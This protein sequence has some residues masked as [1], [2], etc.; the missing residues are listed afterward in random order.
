MTAQEYLDTANP[1]KFKDFF[2]HA[3]GDMSYRETSKAFGIS[4]TVIMHAR[5][6]EP[7]WP[8]LATVK[9]IAEGLGIDPLTLWLKVCE[10]L[11]YSCE[12]YKLMRKMSPQARWE[13]KGRRRSY[14]SDY[15][16]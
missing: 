12:N 1:F 3:M 13:N 16:Y 11:F 2:I 6:G 10:E 8:Y 5:G 4:T 15:I 7:Y 14:E 9:S